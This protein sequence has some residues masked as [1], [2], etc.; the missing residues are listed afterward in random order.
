[1]AL[2]F[3]LTYHSPIIAMEI[4]NNFLALLFPQE[5]IATVRPADDEL[6]FWAIKIDALHW[7]I[8]KVQIRSR[9]RILH[10]SQQGI[11]KARE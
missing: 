8:W 7:K 1:M 3:F 2:K 6:T 5:D 10:W 4:L 9:S 11:Y